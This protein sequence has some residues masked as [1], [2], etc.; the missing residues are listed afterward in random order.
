MSLNISQN[1]HV[2]SIKW[3]TQ[4]WEG[5]NSNHLQTDSGSK[6]MCSVNESDVKKTFSCHHIVCHR[7]GSTKYLDSVE[8]KQG[9]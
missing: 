3:A 4:F 2:P 9:Q 5:K 7:K 1:F 8:I 6:S